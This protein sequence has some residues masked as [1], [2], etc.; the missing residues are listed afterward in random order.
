M[1]IGLGI[2]VGTFLKLFIHTELSKQISISNKYSEHKTARNLNNKSISISNLSLY[3]DE[4]T[5]LS[6]KWNE[7]VRRNKDLNAGAY[8][9]IINSNK[10]AQ[11]NP[12]Y[13]LPAAS[14]IKIPILLLV[15]EMLDNRKLFW[16]ESLRLEKEL[17]GSGAGWMAYE[18]I[19][20]VF[21]VHEVANEMIRVSDN[22]A[23][24]LLIKRLGGINIINTRFKEIGLTNTRINNLLPDLKGTNT[25]TAKDLAL[26][27]ELVDSG[28][29]LT[30]Q[31]RDLFR[32]IMSTSES[33]KLMPAGI[34]KG[35]G[36]IQENIDN[37]LL[38]KGYRVYNKT[39]DIGISY[40][41]IGL[42]QM[43]DGTRAIASFIVKGPFN[44]KRSPELIR[45]MAAA[46]VEVIK[47]KSQLNQQN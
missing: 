33:N 37:K 38:I 5:I 29:F 47:P 6:S 12:D 18:Q 20:K 22:T 32:E 25:T 45:D 34:L 44:D 14:T 28:N 13:I 9:M 10:F 19:G 41:D 42:I 26:A 16:N 24:N 11:I 31:S 3:N 1:G 43:P 36:E 40:G 39:G 17:I 23:T 4:I 8:L 30:P 15:L 35:L 7:L 27:L 2:L 21:P 46:I